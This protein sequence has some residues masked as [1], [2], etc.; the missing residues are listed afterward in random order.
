MLK[1]RK[2]VRGIDIRDIACDG[3]GLTAEMA[4][5]NKLSSTGWEQIVEAWKDRLQA[6]NK[7][8]SSKG[9]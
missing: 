9:L 8:D 1:N 5:L 4:A 7:A 2:Q 6:R 3:W